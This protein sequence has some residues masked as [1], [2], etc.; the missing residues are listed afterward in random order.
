MR[1]KHAFAFG[2]IGAVM[3]TLG[4]AGVASASTTDTNSATLYEN[5]N[6]TGG[7]ITVTSNVYN[8][9]SLHFGDG[10]PASWA[11]SV[12]NN[13]NTVVNIWANPGFAGV[14]DSIAPYSGMSWLSNSAS[15]LTFG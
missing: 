6:Y 13:G 3:T 11:G 15:S 4:A 7:S 8:L 14:Y 5:S 1:L 12:Y 9:G 2:V 10:S